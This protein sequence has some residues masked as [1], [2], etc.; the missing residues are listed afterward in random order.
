[1]YINYYFY[2][3]RKRTT[4][5]KVL[6]LIRISTRK[7][8]KQSVPYELLIKQ[9]VFLYYNYQRFYTSE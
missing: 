8:A 1:M 7:V 6:L 4:P 2:A 9:R 5:L 3:V